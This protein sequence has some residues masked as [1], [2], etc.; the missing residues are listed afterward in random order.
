MS[1]RTAPS[2]QWATLASGKN[3][4]TA[5]SSIV[6]C[7]AH[8]VTG[9]VRIGGSLDKTYIVRLKPP[10]IGVQVVTASSAEIHEDH[11]ALLNSKGELAA[12]LLLEIVESWR[13]V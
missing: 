6:T 12:L 7:L 11:I 5:S 2:G 13:E 4:S 3:V 1:V 8:C 10:Q 9:L